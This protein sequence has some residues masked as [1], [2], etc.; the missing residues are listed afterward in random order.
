LAHWRVGD[1]V[2]PTNE[3]RVRFTADDSPN[4][5]LVEA[6][7]DDFAISFLECEES[8]CPEDLNGDGVVNTEDLLTLLANWGTSGDGDIDGDGVVNTA[9]LLML[10]AAWG[11]CP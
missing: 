3:V 1:F 4:D 6:L 5:S 9:D 7:I 8:D 10:L 2:T 11:D